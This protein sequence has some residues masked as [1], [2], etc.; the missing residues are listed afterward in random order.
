MN[1]MAESLICVA[2]RDLGAAAILM[3]YSTRHAAIWVYD[4]AAK[5]LEAIVHEDPDSLFVRR[6][7][8]ERL[9]REL[10][11]GSPFAIDLWDQIESSWSVDAYQL[12]IGEDGTIAPDPPESSVRHV[13]K[14]LR[15]LLPVVRNHVC[16]K[17]A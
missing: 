6:G 11:R 5:I 1:K 16:E 13:L 15:A 4:A 7:H 12:L 14:E 17:R 9:A 10:P 8:V 3:P 2:E